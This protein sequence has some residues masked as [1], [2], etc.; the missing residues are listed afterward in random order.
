V[1]GG[2]L[3]SAA[4]V[5]TGRREGSVTTAEGSGCGRN[6]CEGEGWEVEGGG[7]G[8]GLMGADVGSGEEEKWGL[9][10]Y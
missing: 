3:H 9:P 7:G 4:H 5:D 1:G 2:P 8:G 10:R 6:G